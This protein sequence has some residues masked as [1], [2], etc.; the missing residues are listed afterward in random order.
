MISRP[1]FL[2]SAC[3]PGM[4]SSLSGPETWI[5]LIECPA[6]FS[7]EL[8]DV[9][10]SQH[11]HHPEYNS[12]LILRSETISDS[13][14]ASRFSS[15]IPELDNFQ[16]SRCIHRKLLPRR[17]GRDASLEQYCTLYKATSS[18]PHTVLILT[19]IIYEKDHLPYYHPRVTHLAFR[20]LHPSPLHDTE[21]DSGVLRIEVVPLP[22]TPLDQDSRLFRTCLALLDT[23]HRYGWGATTNYRKRVIHDV[24]IPREQYQDLYLVMR[25]RHKGLVE[26][27]QE[28]TDPLKHVFEDIGIATYLML[29]WKI[30]FGNEEI[31][32]MDLTMGE[33]WK[34][35]PRPPAGFID[36][37]CGNG[38]LTHILISEGYEGHGI[39]VRER[40]SWKFYPQETQ[41]HL[42][43]NVFNALDFCSDSNPPPFFQ[44]GVFVVANHADELTPWAPVLSTLCSAS[45]YLSIPCC[46][47]DFDT[48]YE[49]SAT[50]MFPILNRTP[51]S[52]TS[53]TCTELGSKKSSLDDF[54]ETLNLGGDGSNSSGYSMYRIW[55][56]TL[57]VHT[58]WEM[59]CE[60]LR[61]PSTRN[62]A[63]IGRKRS[64]VLSQKEAMKN[65]EGIMQRVKE[66]AVFKPRKPEGKSDRH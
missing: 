50:T 10:I 4:H 33:P 64:S 16:Q 36:I 25:E 48:R 17:P 22:G 23:L 40:T 54:I 8:F 43:I 11:I 42:H 49:R 61:I 60:T 34:K 27:W 3:M 9:A 44:P 59:E 52:N 5:P 45:G 2:P 62:W 47:W 32:E 6:N 66:R 55:L 35:W 31:E 39:D 58:G 12:T 20:F 14:F 37:G 21:S 24:L 51:I 15:T 30:T 26:T 65:V 1:K 41:E 13:N 29:L 53:D 19:P 57:S 56:A 46:A 18:S 63:I 28:V 7:E 38:L